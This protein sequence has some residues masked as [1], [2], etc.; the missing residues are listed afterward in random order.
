M[1][2]WDEPN[3]TWDHPLARYDDPRTFAEILNPSHPMFTDIVLDTNHLSV[4]DYIARLRSVLNA[5]AG[6][7]AYASL[8]ALVTATLAKVTVLETEEG[9][10]TTGQN[11][12]AGLVLTRDTAW[13]AADA[14]FQNVAREVGK[15]APDE[16]A[17][18]DVNL[19]LKATPGPRPLPG[20]PT[21]FA[22]EGGDE[23][24]EVGGQCQG[25]PGMVDFYEIAWTTTDPNL[26]TTVWQ[27]L[28]PSKKSNFE[29][30]GLPTGVKIWMRVRGTNTTGT[31]PW[32]D[33]ASTRVP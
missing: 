2:Y 14:D 32:S 5:I 6:H 30:Q 1:P 33:P 20:K 28:S 10:L 9:A 3:L 19:R 12:I 27:Y 15:I 4:A 25:Q 13:D 18:T 31:S 7:P 24:G 29:R 11:A 23:E 16:Q 22:I 17:V 8:A 21:A 26:A